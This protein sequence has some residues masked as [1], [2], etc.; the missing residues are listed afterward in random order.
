MI[1]ALKDR[2]VEH[3]AD[4]GLDDPDQLEVGQR[5]DLSHMFDGKDATDLGHLHEQATVLDHQ[6]VASITQHNE[7]LRDWVQAHPH[8]AL[9]SERAQD[10]L[11]AKVSTAVEHGTGGS[12]P[13][14]SEHV[15]QA[16]VDKLSDGMRERVLC[17]LAEKYPAEYAKAHAANPDLYPDVAGSQVETAAG[18]GPEPVNLIHLSHD[19]L[20]AQ[21]RF[22]GTMKSLYESTPR[23]TAD[24]IIKRV[25]AMRADEVMKKGVLEKAIDEMEGGTHNQAKKLASA[26]RKLLKSVP[27]HEYAKTDQLKAIFARI[28]EAKK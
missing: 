24:A 26:I 25:T 4:F 3:H 6:A 23:P 12:E 20:E 11:S 8:E 22:T 9:N 28:P 18:G 14:L 5:L 27:K 19:G 15:Q 7:Q 21:K 13:L 1:D 2:V 10:V 17:D 16:W